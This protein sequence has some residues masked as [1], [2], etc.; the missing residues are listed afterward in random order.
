MADRYIVVNARPLDRSRFVVNGCENHFKA[1]GFLI[2]DREEDR[3]LPDVFH[4]RA[5]AQ[6]ECDRR[7]GGLMERQR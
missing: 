5:E 1:R 3:R 6:S 2:L 4:S 7:N